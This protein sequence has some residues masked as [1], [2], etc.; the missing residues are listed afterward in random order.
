MKTMITK[1]ALSWI[2]GGWA[3]KLKITLI[4]GLITAPIVELF[5]KYVFNDWQF[6]IYLS[7]L[8]V[9]DTFLGVW[10][11]WKM[12]NISSTGFARLFTKVIIYFFFL[13]VTHVATHFQ[14]GVANEIFAW[15]DTIAYSAIV[16]R[17][18]ISIIEKMGAIS[19]NLIPKWLLAKLQQFDNT[20]KFKKDDDVSGMDTTSA[21]GD[22]GADERTDTSAVGE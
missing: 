4:G 2:A 21:S 5:E 8:I 9:V 3:G 1:L 22:F 18:I 17:E 6:A 16:V 14:D 11:S 19:P 10:K 20:G 12:R 7:I 15:F 13:V